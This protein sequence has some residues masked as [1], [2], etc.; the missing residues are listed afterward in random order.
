VTE[1]T[2]PRNAAQQTGTSVRDLI[3]NLADSKRLLG[4]RYA[5]WILG[6][7][8]LETG[9]ACASMAQDEWGHARLLYAL[10]KDFG[11]DVERLEHGR[12]APEYRN[13]EVLDRTPESWAEFVVLNA[14]VDAALTVQLEALTNSEHAPLR[15]RVGKL[16]DEEYFH[17]AHGLAWANRLGT[18]TEG[19]S[20][21]AGAVNAAYPIVARWFGS[22]G[23][24]LREAW[25]KRVAPVLA[26]AG[27]A[28][29]ANATPDFTGF[30]E[31]TRR[32]SAAGPDAATIARVRGDKN[33]AFLMD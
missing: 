17:A 20:A 19:R 27:R 13:I 16:I 6:A 10:L 8:E 21:L 7:P 3:L 4:T 24:A 33:R 31:S 5:E 15:Q 12:E 1:A 29:S 14:L 22:S 18:T 25:A 28:E 26:A 11:E 30:N 23:A 32:V 2:L 9:I